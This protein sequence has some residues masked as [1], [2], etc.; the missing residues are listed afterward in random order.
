M[1]ASAK[2]HAHLG[3]I[4]SAEDV[5]ILQQQRLHAKTRSRQRGAASCHATA[6][7]N[8]V[9]LVRIVDDLDA[10]LR[11]APGVHL[12]RR[13]RGRIPFGREVERIA[14]SVEAGEVAK[15]DDILGPLL[16]THN[17]CLLPMPC[18]VANAEFF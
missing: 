5:A 3:R 10:G 14:A 13:R 15:S 11:M 7:D 12:R 9:V 8:E 6:N 16:K 18:L 4:A 1:H 2:P 17:A